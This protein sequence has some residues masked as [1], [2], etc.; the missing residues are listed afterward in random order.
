MINT[1]LISISNILDFEFETRIEITESN[2]FDLQE[3]EENCVI[4]KLMNHNQL[5]LSILKVFFYIYIL[6]QN[7]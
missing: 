2:N 7:F 3:F 4:Y 1:F 6:H 5:N